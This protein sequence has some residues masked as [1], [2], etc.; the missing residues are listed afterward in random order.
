MAN[1]KTYLVKNRSAGMVVYKIPEEGVRREFQPG[2]VKKIP[3]AELEKLTYQSGGRTLIENFLQITDE[4]VTDSLNIHTEA[5][6]YMS[7]EQVKELILNGSLD[8][9]LDALDYAPIG[10][11]DLI[12]QYSISLPMNDIEKRQALKNKT[13][14]D[15]TRALE[16]L[17][18]E[19]MVDEG[20]K[21]ENTPSANTS[22]RRTTTNYKVVS[23]TENTNKEEE[24]SE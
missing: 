12:K 2:E 22:K 19:Q 17:R 13:G 9:F 21:K 23:S 16:N 6:Y 14:F 4:K 11:M 24:K 1:T 8:Q 18:N 20:E 7:E 5:E 15:V 10:V 3:Y